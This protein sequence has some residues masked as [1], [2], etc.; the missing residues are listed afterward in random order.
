MMFPDLPN[1]I[2]TLPPSIL[3]PLSCALINKLRKQNYML[4]LTVAIKPKLEISQK[5]KGGAELTAFLSSH[6]PL[7]LVGTD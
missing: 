5:T 1:L 6:C 2:L 3:H 7:I 4:R